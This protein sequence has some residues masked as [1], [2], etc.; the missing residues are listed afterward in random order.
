MTLI[1]RNSSRWSRLLLPAAVFL[2]MFALWYAVTTAALL[3]P[4][5]LPAPAEII[6]GLKFLFV[7]RNFAADVAVSVRRVAQAFALSAAVG[8]PF[9]VIMGVHKKVD[10]ALE[11]IMAFVRYMPVAGFVPLCILWLGIGDAQKV[12]V[13]FIGTFFQLVPMVRDATHALPAEFYETA[14]TLGAS[15]YLII[16][17]V[18]IPYSLPR[19]YDALRI[20]IGITWTYLVVAEIVAAASGIGHVI[21]ESQRY[22]QTANIFAGILT[23]GCL[24][25]VTDMLFRVLESLFFPW[26]RITSK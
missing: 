17:R 25:M 8:V 19:V 20:S 11:P 13:L 3:Q 16:L 24:G 15:N 12:A 18:I 21:I 26:Y 14:R 10:S 6:R 4:Y 9:G 5:F 7:E 22:L 2:A 1:E 23:V